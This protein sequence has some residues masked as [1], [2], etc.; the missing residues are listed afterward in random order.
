MKKETSQNKTPKHKLYGVAESL[1]VEQ[2][3]PCASIS[4]QLNISVQTLS[5]WRKTMQWEQ[6]RDALLTAPNHIR[7]LLVDEIKS[8]S[9]GNES[10]INS[11]A[12]SKL[13]KSLQYFDGKVSLSVVI[14]VLKEF[15]NYMAEIDPKM[16][17]LFTEHH[18]TFINHRA[19]MEALK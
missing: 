17:I 6:Q 1:F 9:Q 15:D 19:K 4:Q 2:G 14:A 3:F 7:K 13:S 5:K 18:K 16:A 12:L 11:D 10:K 8:V